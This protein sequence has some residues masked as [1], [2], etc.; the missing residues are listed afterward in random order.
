[1]EMMRRVNKCVKRLPVVRAGLANQRER[2][3]AE[4]VDGWDTPHTCAARKEEVQSVV[5]EGGWFAFSAKRS[6]R[7]EGN[8]F[9][10]HQVLWLSRGW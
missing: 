1:M 4:R 5:S 2:G 7:V 9:W 10:L 8:V 6:S 3:R